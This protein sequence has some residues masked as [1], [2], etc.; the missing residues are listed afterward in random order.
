SADPAQAGPDPARPRADVRP[1]GG[2]HLPGRALV[3]AA[4][5]QPP[6][7]GLRAVPE[8]RARPLAVRFG[9]PPGGRDHGRERPPGC[10]RG[11]PVEAE[12]G[13]RSDG[14]V[15]AVVI[16]GGHNGLVTAAYL[17][18]AG[19]STLVL[20]RRAEPGGA[21]VTAEIAPGVR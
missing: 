8:P 6:G 7:A 17:A 18:R 15:D 12:G 19:L 1:G 16:G 9:D 11:P 2:Q 10:A 5:L 4:L 13:V 14:G 3:G 21:L 20:E